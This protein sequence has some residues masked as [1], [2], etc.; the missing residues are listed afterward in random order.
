LKTPDQGALRAVVTK[1]PWWRLRYT[2][3]TI[4]NEWEI[5]WS[6]APYK[7]RQAV[8]LC[9]PNGQVAELGSGDCTGRL[10][11]LKVATVGAG[12]AR[13]TIAH[14]IGLVTGTDGQCKYAAWDSFEGKLITGKDNVHAM[15]F[16]N[17][18]ALSTDVLGLKE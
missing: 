12:A 10:F 4:V 15:K 9:C 8:R 6:L 11:Q 16:Q 17:I 13:Q 2:D 18:G 3:G 14:V 7:N 1:R 5:D